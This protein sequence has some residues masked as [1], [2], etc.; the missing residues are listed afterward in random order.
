MGVG[1]VGPFVY[2]TCVGG[3]RARREIG[4][5]PLDGRKRCFSVLTG[6]VTVVDVRRVY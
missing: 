6:V 5:V 4:A 1:S 3:G 2:G